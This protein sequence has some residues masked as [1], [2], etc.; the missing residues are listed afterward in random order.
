MKKTT[1]L[2]LWIA[3]AS[4]IMSTHSFVSA[5]SDWIEF[6]KIVSPDRAADDYFGSS[7]SLSNNFAI[8]GAFYEDHDASGINFKNNAGSAYIYQKVNKDL[9]FKQKIVASDRG[10]G[11]FF[12]Y[13]VSISD[14]FAVVGAMAENEDENGLN[15]LNGAGSVY[16]FKRDS[17]TNN[18]IEHQKIVAPD[19]GA[20]DVFGWEVSVSGNYFIT[21]A[22]LEDH[23]ESGGNELYGSGSAY[24][25][26]YDKSIDTW[27]FQQKIVAPQRTSNDYF[28]E[29]VSISGNHIIVGALREDEDTNEINTLTMAGSAYIFERDTISDLWEF[30]QKI[31]APD[32]AANDQ[33]GSEVAINKND[34][35]VGVPE[36]DHNEAGGEEMIISGSAYIFSKSTLTNKWD[37]VQKIV[38]PDRAASDAFGVSVALHGNHAAVGAFRE[39]EDQNGLNTLSSAG[40][41]YIFEKDNS[42]GHWNIKQKIVNSDRALS[43]EFGYSMAISDSSILACAHFEDEDAAN[44]NFMSKA[45]SAYFFHLMPTL[46]SVTTQPVSDITASTAIGNGTITGLGTS[47]PTQHGVVWSTES[48]PT[49]D[50]LTKTEE[51]GVSSTGSFTSAI[52]GLAENT[53]YFVRAYVIN[54]ADTCY[55]NEVSFKTSFLTLLQKN[56]ENKIIVYP[57]P[58]KDE[59]Y[60]E[61]IDCPSIIEVLDINGRIYLTRQV[62]ENTSIPF[63]FMTT[64]N[65]LIRIYS[66]KGTVVL[67]LLK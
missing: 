51:G 31:V 49:V 21:G 55:G 14:N 19:R 2:K 44:Q 17:T 32:R 47:N 13:S 67:K 56:A 40:S 29:S 43:D 42:T 52:T 7:S 28:G 5:Q 12:G 4:V 9:I 22:Y 39:D 54:A 6:K 38:A 1:T 35:L 60:I 57:N 45:G 46:L 3:F 66:N 59:L 50:L 58:V 16:V 41:A 63:N 27:I 30:Q 62:Y 34:I 64:G 23:D 25:Y 37:F 36:E 26:K 10:A 8:I 48:N 18:W 65:Y 24:I 11:D 15:T 53:S 33:F 61:G 20:D